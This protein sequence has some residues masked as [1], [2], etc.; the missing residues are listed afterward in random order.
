MELYVEILAHYLAQ[1]NARLVFPDLQ[2]NAKEIVEL[3]C[4]QA[5]CQIQKIVRDDSLEEQDINGYKVGFKLT[6]V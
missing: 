6:K 3:R 5:L 2:L 1:E 4:Y